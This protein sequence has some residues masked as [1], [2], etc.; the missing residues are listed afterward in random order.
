MQRSVDLAY[1]VWFWDYFGFTFREGN[2][3]KYN[4]YMHT[5]Q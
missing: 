3:Q 2:S 5:W 4:T 1:G